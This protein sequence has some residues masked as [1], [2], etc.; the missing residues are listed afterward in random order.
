[1][2]FIGWFDALPLNSDCH[3]RK[4]L[5]ESWRPPPQIEVSCQGCDVTF[6]PLRTAF[7]VSRAYFHHSI[8]PQNCLQTLQCYNTLRRRRWSGARRYSR[9]FVRA[10]RGIF[11]NPSTLSSLL[12]PPSFL[13]LSHIIFLSSFYFLWYKWFLACFL[14]YIRS[15]VACNCCRVIGQSTPPPSHTHFYHINRYRKYVFPHFIKVAWGQG[16]RLLQ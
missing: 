8:R 9:V 3:S 2:Q 6:A 16:N 11:R 14:F 5:R 7:S 10:F 13:V 1:M 4:R 15:N 12:Y